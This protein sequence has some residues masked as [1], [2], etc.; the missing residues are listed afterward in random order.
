MA[1][2]PRGYANRMETNYRTRLDLLVEHVIRRRNAGGPRVHFLRRVRARPERADRRLV[3]A[4]NRDAVGVGRTAEGD[5]FFFSSVRTSFATAFS[6]SK[7]PVPFIA[8]ASNV[9]S[10]LK[11]SWPYISSIGSAVGRSR[12]LNCSA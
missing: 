1:S 6:V 9:G 2:L 12:L 8:T 3:Q 4:R 7:T 11:F 5:H 10:P